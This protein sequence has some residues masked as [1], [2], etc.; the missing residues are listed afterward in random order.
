MS[1]LYWRWIFVLLV[2]AVLNINHILQIL[3]V[4]VYIME[5]LYDS[6]DVAVI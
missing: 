5:Q 1:F 6:Q 2:I 4:E 3:L